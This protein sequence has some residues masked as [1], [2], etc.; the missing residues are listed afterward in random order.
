[1][2]NT[3]DDYV[4]RYSFS[5]VN[6]AIGTWPRPGRARPRPRPLGAWPWVAR[7]LPRARPWAAVTGQRSLVR[8]VTG[9][10]FTLSV[11]IK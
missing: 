9:P 2:L 8:K 4:L 1:M 6:K 10:T 5:G 3:G 11:T 7:P